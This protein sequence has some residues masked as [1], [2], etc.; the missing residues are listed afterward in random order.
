MFL[1]SY[2]NIWSNDDD[3]DDDDNDDSLKMCHGQLTSTKSL[4][5]VSTSTVSALTLPDPLHTDLIPSACTLA[6][7]KETLIQA[8]APSS[9]VSQ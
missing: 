8:P 4:P 5:V 1:E 2:C 9:S 7:G 6:G 3:G